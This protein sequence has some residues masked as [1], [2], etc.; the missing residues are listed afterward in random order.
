MPEKP[1]TFRCK[2][3]GDIHEYEG[4]RPVC[5]EECGKLKHY[6]Q[7]QNYKRKRAQAVAKGSKEEH[8]CGNNSFLTDIG[9]ANQ[10]EIARVLGLD[11]REVARL[12]RQ[13]L[14][15]IRTN[16]ELKNIW[17]S[18]KEE[19]AQGGQFPEGGIGKMGRLMGP[20]E[21]AEIMLDCQSVVMDWTLYYEDLIE[22]GDYA[23]AEKV[24]GLVSRFR[25]RLALAQIE[26]LRT[27]EE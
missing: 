26:M 6:A 12:E 20:E 8:F 9:G 23:A 22:A 13:A 15:K 1:K 25:Q 27:D 21:W 18:L 4:R 17:G 10:A 7:I 24:L 2:G 19:L 14:L 16:P 5:C 3:C 11:F